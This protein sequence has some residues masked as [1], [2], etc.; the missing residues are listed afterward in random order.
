MRPLL[1]IALASLQE[2]ESRPA[3]A[4]ASAPASSPASEAEAAR[5]LAELEATLRSAR[6]GSGTESR[7]SALPAWFDSARAAYVEFAATH[8]GTEAAARARIRAALLLVQGEEKLEEG[9]A[10]LDGLAA[11]LRAVPGREPLLAEVLMTAGLL[12]QQAGR[13]EPA[14][15][16]FE[17]VL[18]LR[19]NE[20]ATR[21]AEGALR[22]LEALSRIRPGEEAPPFEARDLQGNVLSPASL[23]GRVALLEFWTSWSPPSRERIPV[24]RETHAALREKGFE[25]VGIC[26]DPSERTDRETFEAFLRREEISWPQVFDGDGF[27]SPV[28][29]SFAVE[30]VPTSFLL[31]RKGRIRHVSPRKGDL[32]VLVEA[33][34][35]EID[36]G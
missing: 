4:P 16:R 1:L 15:A 14:R 19:A 2:P 3:S 36:N 13:T 30:R 12:L 20:T 28:A 25:I 27:R 35:G 34:L 9:F 21:T 32:R 18:A 17:E 10:L 5:A 24:L 29:R 31:D 33:L 26:L 7:P 6:P 22:A 11:D 8:P 23:R